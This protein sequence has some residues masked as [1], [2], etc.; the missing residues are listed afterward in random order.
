MTEMIDD[1][2]HY[3][4][5]IRPRELLAGPFRIPTGWELGRRL[6]ALR[7][8]FGV[9]VPELAL[10]VNLR[11]CQIEELEEYGIASMETLLTL[12]EG[13]CPDDRLMA[14]FTVPGFADRA[15]LLARGARHGSGPRLVP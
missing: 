1:T 6:A 7:A 11:H 5:A 15:E 3:A 10:A 14:A 2:E 8:R 12:V 13:L 9:T 4:Y